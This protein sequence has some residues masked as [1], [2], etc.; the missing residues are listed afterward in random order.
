MNGHDT[1][2]LTAAGIIL[3]HFSHAHAVAV[4]EPWRPY[5]A[6]ECAEHDYD[7]CDTT[8]DRACTLIINN[9]TRND[10]DGSIPVYSTAVG[11][12]IFNPQKSTMMCAYSQDG[13]TDDRYNRGCG[14]HHGDT[15]CEQRHTNNSC[16]LDAKAGVEDYD[17]CWWGPN[18][19]KQMLERQQG[20]YNEVVLDT[21]PWL[22]NLPG[23][24]EAFFYVKDAEKLNDTVDA[25]HTFRNSYP[26]AC[27][28]LLEMDIHANESPFS[29]SSH[30]NDGKTQCKSTVEYQS[31]SGEDSSPPSD[32]TKVPSSADNIRTSLPLVV[33]ASIISTLL[34]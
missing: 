2:D 23:S 16:V 28:P 22:N 5:T 34:Y 15:A 1:D 12:I 11:G 13:G 18:D 20:V 4:G 32:T 3:H 8:G 26:D 7:G 24:I 9:Q 25:Y 27:V 29:Y 14:C 33:I 10:D 6:E 21:T 31:P 30:V 19:L 17:V